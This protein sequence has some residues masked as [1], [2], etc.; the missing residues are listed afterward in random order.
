VPDGGGGR[1]TRQPVTRE[2]EFADVRGS[3]SQEAGRVKGRENR[4]EKKNRAGTSKGQNIPADKKK[5]QTF[6]LSLLVFRSGCNVGVSKMRGD[7]CRRKRKI[8][9]V[10]QGEP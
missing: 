8:P 9:G 10:V 2:R 6:P 1:E 4:G 3:R 7:K 5:A